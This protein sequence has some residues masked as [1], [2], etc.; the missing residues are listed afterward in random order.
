MLVSGLI[1]IASRKSYV[2]KCSDRVSSLTCVTRNE[3]TVISK[4]LRNVQSKS[5]RVAHN[6]PTLIS[7]FGGSVWSIHTFSR[8]KKIHECGGY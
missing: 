7:S 5:H 2:W 4:H 6:K 3:M 8:V 1:D